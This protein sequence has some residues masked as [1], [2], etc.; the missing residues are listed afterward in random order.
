MYRILQY[1]TV[2]KQLEIQ[3]HKFR[4]LVLVIMTKVQFE[5][6]GFYSSGAFVYYG[7]NDSVCSADLSLLLF[8]IN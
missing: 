6:N 4:N 3:L 5:H 8:V 2:F 7:E 1:S